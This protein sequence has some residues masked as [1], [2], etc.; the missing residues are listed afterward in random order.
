MPG[1]RLALDAAAILVGNV[2]LDRRV[3]VVGFLQTLR[4]YLVEVGERS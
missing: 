2:V 3:E 4:E 1:E